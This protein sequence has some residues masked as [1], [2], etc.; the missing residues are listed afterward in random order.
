MSLFAIQLIYVLLKLEIRRR[1][2]PIGRYRND[3][4]KSLIKKLAHDG[5]LSKKDEYRF[6]ILKRQELKSRTRIA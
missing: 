2:M 3:E 4:I 6:E 1:V 5:E